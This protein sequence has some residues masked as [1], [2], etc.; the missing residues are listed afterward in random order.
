MNLY[1]DYLCFKED[2]QELINFFIE[3]DSNIIVRFK[4]VLAIID[5]LYDKYCDNST[6]DSNEE[7]IFETGYTYVFDRFNIIELLLNKTFNKDLEELEKFSKT[8]NLVLYVNDFKDEVLN[9][10]DTNKSAIDEFS[11]YEDKI[12]SLLENKEHATDIDFALLDDI[13]VRVFSEM[14][15]DF[16]GINEIFYDI[17]LKLEII[18]E[19]DYDG[20]EF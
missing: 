4:H 1:Q 7:L 20:D 13:S 18:D 10:D 14:N 8:I 11:Q 17:G 2:K 5:F 15:T 19:D 9:I 3:N 6:L 16:Y 12:L